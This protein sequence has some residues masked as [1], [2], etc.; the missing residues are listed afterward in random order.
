MKACGYITCIN[1]AVVRYLF[2]FLLHTPIIMR[3]AATLMHDFR[4]GFTKISL[5]EGNLCKNCFNIFAF[6][7]YRNC[8]GMHFAMQQMK[9]VVAQVLRRYEIYRDAETEEPDI[10]PGIT[11]QSKNGIQLKLKRVQWDADLC[12]FH[13]K[14]LIPWNW[15]YGCVPTQHSFIIK[16]RKCTRMFVHLDVF[17]V[18]LCL[19]IISLLWLQLEMSCSKVEN[20]RKR[21]N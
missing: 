6:L 20:V 18:S 13:W 15:F 16:W 12:E 8:I 3:N 10:I 2:F 17:L 7:T 5:S 4:M 1:Q 14:H 11:L 21:R 19:Y 9:V